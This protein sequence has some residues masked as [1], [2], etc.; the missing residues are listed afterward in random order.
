MFMSSGR[1]PSVLARL[2]L[3]LATGTALCLSFIMM[4]G[5]VELRFGSYTTKNRYPLRYFH[6]QVTAFI[7]KW[8]LHKVNS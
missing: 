2:I 8:R 3:F 5:R 6:P 1:S 7:L 4:L